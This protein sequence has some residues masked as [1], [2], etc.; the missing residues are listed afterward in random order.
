VTDIKKKY[1]FDQLLFY[2]P[3]NRALTEDNEVTSNTIL[4]LL[5]GIRIA[6]II[7]DKIP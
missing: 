6:A 4:I 3:F 7:G 5:A 1:D 2:N